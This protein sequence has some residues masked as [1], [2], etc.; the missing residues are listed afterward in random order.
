LVVAVALLL[1]AAAAPFL[2]IAPAYAQPPLLT[3]TDIP[4]DLTR[5]DWIIDGKMRLVGIRIDQPVVRAAETLPVTVTWQALKPMDV[6]YSVFVHVFGRDGQK[7]GQLDTYPGLGAW[8]TTLLSPGDVIVDSYPV[9]IWP[10]AEQAAPA[11][12]RVLVGLYDYNEP[13]RPAKPTVTANGQPV[14]FQVGRAKLVPWQ[15]PEAKPAHAL[16]VNFGDGIRLAGYELRAGSG[17]DSYALQLV[18]QPAVRPSADYTVFI[19]VW[20]GDKQM[21]GFDGPPVGGDYPT[22]WWESGEVIVDEHGLDWAGA[23]LQP[24]GSGRYRLLVGLYRLDTGARL[25]AFDPDGNP[26]PNSA[27]NILLAR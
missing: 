15:W 12:L 1:F 8:P 27:L 16:D 24:I 18:W 4:D 5:L 13:G 14:N 23:G 21:A 17:A 19:Q 7:V 9:S 6:N 22:S 20:D 26:L 3:E 11:A 2:Y 25:P 10:E